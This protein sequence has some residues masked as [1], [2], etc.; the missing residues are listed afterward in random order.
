MTG[1]PPGMS[2]EEWVAWVRE[3]L[4]R[5]EVEAGTESNGHKPSCATTAEAGNG[6]TFGFWR[7]FDPTEVFDPGRFFRMNQTT[8]FSEVFEPPGMTPP[9]DDP[10]PPAQAAPNWQLH[11]IPETGDVGL[12]FTLFDPSALEGLPIPERRWLVPDWIPMAR[13]TGLYGAGGEGK[14][15]L[16]QLL[17]TACAIDKLWLGL[18]TRKCRS[19]LFFAEDDQDEMHIRQAAINEHYGCSFK[20]LGAMRW[21]PMLGEDCRLI[22][23]VGPALEARL[24]AIFD[25]LLAQAKDHKPA[26]IVADTLSDVFAGNENDRTQVR[27]FCRL[28]LGKLGIET[29]AAILVPAHPSQAGLARGTGDSAS[30]AWRGSFRSQLFLSS[31]SVN[32]G[33]PPNPNVRNLMRTKANWAQRD[34]TIELR[35]QHGVFVRTDKPAGIVG[36]IL[37]SNCEKVTLAL[38]ERMTVENQTLSSNRHSGNYA[39]RVLSERPAK[40]RDNFLYADFVKAVQALLA[41]GELINEQYGR[42]SRPMFKLV[43]K[44][45]PEDHQ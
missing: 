36:S 30:T 13:A 21:A 11:P 8:G 28:A 6:A 23:F 29:G 1:R 27:Q 33:D 10:V 20:D 32:G 40:E 18:R 19:L 5:E 9:P 38:V 22:D 35:W 14:T 26:L 42:P 44:P 43:R 37:R 25:H 15:L 31:P 12:P 16:A 24:T 17:G 34:D 39:P 7:T 3:K 2:D 41:R 4:A 45:Q